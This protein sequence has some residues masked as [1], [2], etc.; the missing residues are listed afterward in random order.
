[1][2]SPGPEADVYNAAAPTRRRVRD[3]YEA[4]SRIEHRL[5]ERVVLRRAICRSL[6]IIRDPRSEGSQRLVEIL[7]RG[8]GIV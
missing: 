5:S 8:A 4:F 3:A 6:W 2:P 1:V 7:R